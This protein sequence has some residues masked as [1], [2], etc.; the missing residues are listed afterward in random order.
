VARVV[1]RHVPLFWRVFLP[2][3]AVLGVACLALILQPPN[4]DVP[5][6]LCGLA[7][8]LVVDLVLM[9]RAVEPLRR[10]TELARR[11]DPLRPGARLA[12]AGTTAEVRELA[13]AFND[14]LARLE[15]ERRASAQRA[16]AE[17]ED[18]R[19][20][21]AA[22]LHDQLGQDLT[23][24]ALQAGR[25]AAAVPEPAGEEVLAVRDGVLGAVEDVRRL[26]RSLRPEALDALG[27]VPALTNLVERLGERTGV[28]VRRDLERHLP[29]LAPDAE[30]AVFRVAQES[31]TNA[32]R[33]AGATRLEV[34]LRA[35]G[36]G[37]VLR[38]ADDGRGLPHGA[39]VPGGGLR[40]MR[41]RALLAGGRL[42]V[43]PGPEGRG[44][45]VCL[46]VPAAP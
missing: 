28:E 38:V 27:L 3:A 19:R 40:A 43:G 39:E 29:P 21:L 20:R 31:L 34:R 44:S 4:G 32:L 17:R 24:I 26:A 15:T 11:A 13:R 22:E 5:I 9:R 35:E 8:L 46:R 33:H 6:L 16:L 7:V 37:A 2:N 14:M 23:A 25:A 10:L 41:E 30:L 42:E 18:E 12:V 36:A 45:E 1:P